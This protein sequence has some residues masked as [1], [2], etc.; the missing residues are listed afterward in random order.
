MLLVRRKESK[1]GKL[2]GTLWAY[3]YLLGHIAASYDALEFYFIGTLAP[4]FKKFELRNFCLSS[5]SS[6][7]RLHNLRKS[8]LF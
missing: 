7:L 3:L 6:D 2:N 4:D 1:N 5:S 8:Y